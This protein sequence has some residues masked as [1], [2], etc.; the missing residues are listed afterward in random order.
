[1]K[2]TKLYKAMSTQESI[3]QSAA[4]AG[5]DLSLDTS[6]DQERREVEVPTNQAL[7]TTS[8]GYSQ[9]PRP[10]QPHVKDLLTEKNSTKKTI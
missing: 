3:Q 1:V 7:H 8:Q 4:R 9:V 5:I 2:R 6:Q 10:D